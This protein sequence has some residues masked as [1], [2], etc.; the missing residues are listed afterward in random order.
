MKKTRK[1]I[2]ITGKTGR[3]KSYLTE[4]FLAKEIEKNQ[5]V[6][7][8][9]SMAEYTAGENYDSFS[10]F[11]MQCS[12]NN[13][14][15]RAVHIVPIQSDVEAKKLFTFSRYCGVRH[16]LIVEEASKYCSPY[17]IDEALNDLVRYGRHWNVSLVFSAQRFAQLNKI[18]TSQTDAFLS[19]QQTEK[20][21]LK[22][23]SDFLNDTDKI[24]DLKKFQF[25][26]FG[27]ES[28]FSNISVGEV[29]TL[30]DKKIKK[31]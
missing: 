27:D 26:A 8:A 10:H 13:G 20:N 15:K 9:D 17:Q 5:P 6:V 23:I 31:V 24:R 1:I 16:C 18:V 28:G 4:H 25:V 22:A 3:G 2:T 30:K 12:K 29:L 14:L 19:F 21:D 11:Y 7:I